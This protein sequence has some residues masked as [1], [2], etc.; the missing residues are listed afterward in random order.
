MEKERRVWSKEGNGEL[1][2]VM[3]KVE[4]SK[5]GNERRILKKKKNGKRLM[6]ML[7]W[8]INFTSSLSDASLSICSH[9]IATI[10]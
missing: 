8:R 2:K 10:F 6:G 9:W 1:K 3:E 5:N 4:G 7:K